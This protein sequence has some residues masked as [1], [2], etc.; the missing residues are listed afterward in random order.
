MDKGKHPNEPSF[1]TKKKEPTE[2]ELKSLQWEAK[3][4]EKLASERLQLFLILWFGL[5]FLFSAMSD[6]V[7]YYHWLAAIVISGIYSYGF[8]KK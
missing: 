6:K 8:Y 4:A 5:G 7:S 1:I 3:K 2:D